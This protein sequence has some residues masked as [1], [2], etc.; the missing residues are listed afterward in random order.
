LSVRGEINVLIAT[1][2]VEEG[3]DVKRVLLYWYLTRSE[4]KGYI[5]M[6]G[7]SSEGCFLSF[8]T[9]TMF[10]EQYFF[11]T[12]EMEARVIIFRSDNYRGA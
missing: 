11:M 10:Q 5:Q 7:R 6:K 8:K 4:H 3:V 1:S 12:Q 2:V 9:A